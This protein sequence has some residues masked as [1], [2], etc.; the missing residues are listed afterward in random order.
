[1]YK[2]NLFANGAKS[3][4]TYK[5]KRGGMCCGSGCSSYG[6]GAN[7]DNYLLGLVRNVSIHSKPKL[8]KKSRGGGG[9]KFIR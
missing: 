4:L 9:L 6:A 7:M 3:F 5:H 2:K 1:M 8:K